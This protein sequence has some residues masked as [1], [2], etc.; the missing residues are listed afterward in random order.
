MRKRTPFG[1]LVASTA[2]KVGGECDKEESVD[3]E[4]ME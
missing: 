2:G 3:V 4:E 1:V